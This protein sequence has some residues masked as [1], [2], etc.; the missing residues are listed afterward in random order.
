MIARHT[1]IRWNE[2]SQNITPL[3][4]QFENAFRGLQALTG[5]TAAG[6]RAQRAMA[7][8][9]QMVDQQAAMLAYV[10]DFRWLALAC[11]LCVPIVFLL[12]GARARKGAA[13]AAH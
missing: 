2:L 5:S 3:N 9:A 10:D 4:A 6:L 8:V 11:F 1:Q 7:M 12:R 13:A